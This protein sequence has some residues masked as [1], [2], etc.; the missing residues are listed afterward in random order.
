MGLPPF[1]PYK[2]GDLPIT[3][4]L[5]TRVFT[6]PPYI[7]PEEGLIEQIIEAFKK[8]VDNYTKLF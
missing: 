5:A 6:I 4:D 8:V 2:R 7:E 1:K 3:E